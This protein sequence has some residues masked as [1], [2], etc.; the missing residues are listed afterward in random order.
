MTDT[1]VIVLTTMPPGE[2]AEA[3]ARTLVEERLAACVNLLPPMQSVYRWKGDVQQEAEQ[4]LVMKTT[5]A[6]LDALTARLA[7]LHPYD[8]PECLVVPVERAS[9]A[10]GTWLAD[11][12]R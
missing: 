1:F 7:A 6:R 12:V 5:R 8:V 9:E 4:Q 3:L 10:Y 2:G 11:S